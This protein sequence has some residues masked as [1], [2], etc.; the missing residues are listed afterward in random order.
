VDVPGVDVFERLAGGSDI[1]EW[2]G[3]GLNDG[4]AVCTIEAT[5]ESRCTKHKGRE[6]DQHQQQFNK[7]QLKNV[8][9]PK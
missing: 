1:A 7:Q 6:G 3:S 5:M 4:D 2:S 8:E 9:N